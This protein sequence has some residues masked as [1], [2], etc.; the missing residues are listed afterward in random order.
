M[1]S[2][3]EGNDTDNIQLDKKENL[4]HPAVIAEKS[5]VDGPYAKYVLFVL[6]LVYILNFV[7][8]QLLLLMVVQKRVL[9]SATHKPR[10]MSTTNTPQPAQ[11]TLP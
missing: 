4:S 7:D 3:I 11:S 10:F 5:E 1:R 8:R 6:F 9:C 2:V